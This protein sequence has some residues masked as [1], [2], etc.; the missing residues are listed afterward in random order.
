MKTGFCR[1]K[2]TPPLGTPIIGYYKERLT[3]DVIDDLYT[4]VA[5]FDDGETKAVVVAV[6]LCL[7]G[8]DSCDL[9]RKTISEF[10]GVA[11]DAV[12]ISCNH[13]HTGPLT[14]P[15]FASD[16]KPDP[17]YMEFLR[18]TIRDAAAYALRD[19][20][21]SRFFVAETD[22]EGLTFVRRFKMKDGTIK[23][24]EA[25][26]PDIVCPVGA[27]NETVKVLKILREG[28]D[29]LFIVNLGT[30]SDTVR[31]DRIS[32]DWSGYV[33]A[34]LEGALPGTN[35]MVLMAPQGD[36]I[37]RD[38]TRKDG[39]LVTFRKNPDD[40]KEGAPH[41][42]YMGRVIA[43]KVLTVCD[44]A[45][46]I[47]AD[48]IRFGKLEVEVPSHQENDRLEEAKRINDLYESGRAAELNL[49]PTALTFTVAEA[50][51]IL[52]LKDGPTSFRQTM[53]ALR[54]GDLVLAGFPGEPFTALRNM[55]DAKTPFENTMVCCLVNDSPGYFPYPEA[56]DEGGYE[57][58]ASVFGRETGNILVNGMLELLNTLK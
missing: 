12:F 33:C 18:V 20:K 56:Y 44:R 25:G 40:V 31:G 5:A 23:K 50:R 30:H 14:V 28:G 32:A 53:F 11:E 48:R 15:D 42:R 58:L 57:V 47:G 8:K 2:I 19:M 9:F 17:A 16:K 37:H 34:T 21:E 51:R 22:V 52:N 49:Q 46:E 41:A 10:C 36:S 1:K 39:A 4:R 54:L 13:T 7:L 55:V 3:S 43:G 35:C 6:D 45:K 27:P 24:P 38:L 26:D 29:D